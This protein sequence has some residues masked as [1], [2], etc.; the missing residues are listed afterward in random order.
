MAAYDENDGS[1]VSHVFDGSFSESADEWR[2]PEMV[3]A[4]ERKVGL[5]NDGSSTEI[6]AS[7]VSFLST[8]CRH[9]RPVDT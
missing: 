2:R 1:L 8:S 5:V 4:S 6:Y 7:G 9:V 3:Q